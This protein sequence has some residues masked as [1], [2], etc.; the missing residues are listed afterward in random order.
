MSETIALLVEVA[1][2]SIESR[3]V[4]KLVLAATVEPE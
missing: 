3:L 2:E 4:I 1:G